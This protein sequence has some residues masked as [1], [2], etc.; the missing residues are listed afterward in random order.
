MYVM[1]NCFNHCCGLN[2]D[3][4]PVAK[5]NTMKCQQ[6][7]WISTSV[8]NTMH[9][10]LIQ[11]CYLLNALQF[12][13][14]IMVSIQR[15]VKIPRS[16]AYTSI[17]IHIMYIIYKLDIHN[18]PVYISPVLS[19]MVNTYLSFPLSPLVHSSAYYM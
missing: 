18:V 16:T 19:S 2:N 5:Y 3:I 10:C 8:I 14:I 9:T 13:G 15:K 12:A 11:Y 4:L 1:M 6:Y 17:P 7:S